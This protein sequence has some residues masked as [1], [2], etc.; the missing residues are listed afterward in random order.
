MS[1]QSFGVVENHLAVMLEAGGDA[2]RAEHFAAVHGLALLD[3]RPCEGLVLCFDANGASLVQM[4][5]GAPGPVRA[6]FIAGAVAHRRK[7]GGGAGQL[8]A[9]AVGIKTGIRPR[10][11][12]ATAGLGKDA[13]V[14]ATLGCSVTLLERSPVIVELLSAGLAQ[15]S[16][17]PDVAAII[18]RMHL[19]AEDGR[20]FMKAL[21]ASTQS[22]DA[23]DVVYLDPM[24]PHRDKSA[25][26]KKEMRVFREVVGNDPDANELLALA[27]DV[28]RYRVV[29]KRP[30]KAPLLD[31]R[32]PS[33]TIEGQSSRYDIYIRK[34][35][36]GLK[37]TNG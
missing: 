8:V 12:D 26:V 11:L 4:G 22:E 1:S 15:A 2:A 20:D 19:I 10:V 33:L 5:K 29:V 16:G 32:V 35:L 3:Q 28:A 36:E 14:L 13:F 17:E 7:F 27:L 21:N 30:R 24:F 34:S 25:L 6:S 23:Y 37:N 31:D 18:A 9:K